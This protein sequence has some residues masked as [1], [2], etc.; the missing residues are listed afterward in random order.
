MDKNPEAADTDGRLLSYLSPQ[1]DWILSDP[2]SQQNN[3]VP[4]NSLSMVGANC[5]LLFYLFFP[6][7]VP[8]TPALTAASGK[9]EKIPGKTRDRGTCAECAEG[10]RASHSSGRELESDKRLLNT[11]EKN[12]KCFRGVLSITGGRNI[13]REFTQ[14]TAE[15]FHRY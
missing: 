5:H 10:G 3:L 6:P 12:I 2:L 15:G 4:A 1:E 7:S 9:Y 13:K 8:P 14:V 11:V